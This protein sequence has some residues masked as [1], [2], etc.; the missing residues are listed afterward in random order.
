MLSERAKTVFAI[1]QNRP[2]WRVRI[3]NQ[4]GYAFD[5]GRFDTNASLAGVSVEIFDELATVGLIQR[6]QAQTIP[7]GRFT[8]LTYHVHQ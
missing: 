1:M 5:L 6:T 8:L 3:D 2:T 7:G 4:Y